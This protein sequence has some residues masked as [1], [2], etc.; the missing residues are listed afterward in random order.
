[1]PVAIYGASDDLIEVDG[2]IYEEFNHN[3]D[4]PALL[5]F[6]DGTVL[7]VTF[8]QDG[9][10]RITPVVTG[11]ATFTHEFGQDDK[12]HSDKATLTGDVRWVVY[13]SA[14]ASAK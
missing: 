2:D 1:M 7:K 10:W 13:G 11:S 3:D 14:M 6:S 9:I 4:E 12:R 8:D 5:G